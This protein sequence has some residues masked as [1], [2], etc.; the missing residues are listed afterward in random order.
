MRL[1]DSHCH[2]DFEAFDHDR[3]AVLRKAAAAGVRI[4]VVPAVKRDTWDRLVELCDASGRL[5]YA[6]G[7]HPLFVG[8]HQ[9][10]HLDE[11]SA[12][13]SSLSPVAVGEIG[14]DFFDKNLDKGKQLSIFEHQL[15]IARNHSLP[16]ILHVRKAHDEVLTLLRRHEIRGGIA[17]AFNGSR[18][19]A[20]KYLELGFKLGFGGM[21]T[22]ERSRRLRALARDLPLDALVLETDAPDMTVA[23]FRGRRN[24][25]EYIPYVLEA[26]ASVRPEPA[27][28]IAAATTRNAAGVLGLP[29]GSPED[30]AS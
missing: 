11:L 29:L 12:R 9:P 17:H 20:D 14:L 28:E 6:L 25:P 3:E 19:Q 5:Y 16:A 24:S 10:A 13:V 4:I 8:M 22:F 21:L 23:R 1:I 18:Q 2:L 30:H 26:M 7:L 27:E 15:E